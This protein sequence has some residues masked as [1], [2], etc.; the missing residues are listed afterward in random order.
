MKR[1]SISAL[2][3]ATL[4][5]ACGCE[6]VLGIHGSHARDGG[7]SAPDGSAGASGSSDAAAGREAGVDG[8]AGATGGASGGISGTG[9]AAGGGGT[10]GAPTPDAGADASMDARDGA[11]TSDGSPD[12]SDG[13]TPAPCP[14][15]PKQTVTLYEFADGPHG[16]PNGNMGACSFPIALLPLSRHYGA[17]GRLFGDAAACG[18]CLVVENLAETKTF[19]VQIIDSTDPMVNTV[20][21][22]KDV[23]QMLTAGG[24]AEQARVH[25]APC[26]Y[27]GTIQ[28]AFKD[29]GSPSPILLNHRTRPTKVEIRGAGGTTWT[30]MTHQDYNYWTP[31]N[32][33]S[34]G[35]GGAALR[36]TDEAGAVIQ[37][38]D[39]SLTTN[40]RDT[41]Q[42][43]PLCTLP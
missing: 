29:P 14:A 23:F 43:F 1:G 26:S 2:L 11:G 40:F 28:V 12:T 21:V 35:A 17:V 34:P 30:P 10:G 20:S 8:A 32:G 27:G 39:L 24:G 6:A 9:G 4:T 25:F 15:S 31:P 19:E 36:V 16:N 38:G 7:A 33:Y 42:Q 5:F 37:T 41:G 13:P 18:A 22:D 3:V